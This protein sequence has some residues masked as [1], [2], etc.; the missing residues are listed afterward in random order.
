MA[1]GL[2]SQFC[3]IKPLRNEGIYSDELKPAGYAKGYTVLGGKM[4]IYGFAILFALI[5]IILPGTV[6]SDL[7][8]PFADSPVGETVTD[9]R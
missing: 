7:L 8:S 6:F 2:C 5:M 4:R 9:N 1:S 3:E